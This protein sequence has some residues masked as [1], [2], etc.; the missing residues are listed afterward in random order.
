MAYLDPAQI[1]CPPPSGWSDDQLAVDI[2][3]GLGRSGKVIDLLQHLPYLRENDDDKNVRFT[4]KHR[5]HLI[6]AT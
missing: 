5:P 3:R 4:Q 2:L 6:F 1:E